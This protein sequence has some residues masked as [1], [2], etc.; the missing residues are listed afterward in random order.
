MWRTRAYCSH[1]IHASMSLFFLFYSTLSFLCPSKYVT[2]PTGI[3]SRYTCAI[4]RLIPA[5]NSTI[6]TS[7]GSLSM[8]RAQL[9]RT[10]SIR[11][12][13]CHGELP[14][15]TAV[16]TSALSILMPLTVTHTA[17]NDISRR[18]HY[19]L[20]I[21]DKIF[22]TEQESERCYQPLSIAVSR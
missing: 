10:A 12:G 6:S 9:A 1:Y 17:K 15:L 13:R 18:N 14:R 16:E 20:S 22:H 8:L 5:L 7:Q 4:F 19:S 3:S 2:T 21:E 11:R